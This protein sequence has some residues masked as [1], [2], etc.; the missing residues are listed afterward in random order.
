MQQD[1]AIE[2][3]DK[4][5]A[6][7]ADFELKVEGAK[8]ECPVYTGAGPSNSVAQSVRLEDFYRSMMNRL[9]SSSCAK[10]SNI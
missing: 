8:G 9:T 10:F 2:A 7:L 1:R 4:A 6:D 5:I 3:V